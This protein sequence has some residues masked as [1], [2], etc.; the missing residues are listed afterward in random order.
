M[1]LLAEAKVAQCPVLILRYEDLKKHSVPEMK[2][3]TDF[4]GFSF[5]KKEVSARLRGG[6]PQFY[7]N[8]TVDFQHFTPAEEQF[9]HSLIHNT[10]LL[11]KEYGVYSMF[12][13]IDQ[14]L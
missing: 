8:H 3:V 11:M 13:H 14:Y 6:Y 5:T 10:T 7:R 4:L 1:F 2:R 12:P 9:L